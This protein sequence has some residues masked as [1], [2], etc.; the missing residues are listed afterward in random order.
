MTGHVAALGPPNSGT[1][2]TDR[3]TTWSRAI[4]VVGIPGVIAL[5]ATWAWT[6]EMPKITKQ[7]EVNHQELIIM[8]GMVSEMN[9]KL[10][11]QLRM[12][13]WICA[14]LQKTDDDR[15]RCFE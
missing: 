13:R 12:Q 2:H 10:D 8:R 15:R 9:S 7:L 3:I 11:E 5:I 1:V 4:A 6:I 14:G